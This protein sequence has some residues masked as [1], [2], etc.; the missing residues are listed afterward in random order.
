MSEG[1]TIAHKI[2]MIAALVFVVA[3][4]PFSI[5]AC[6]AAIIIVV[7]TWC[8]EGQWRTKFSI[9]RH[10]LLLQLVI[11]LFFLQLLGLAFSDNLHWGWFSLEKKIFLLLVPVVLATTVIRLSEKEVKY[12]VTA[13]I[14]ACFTGTLLC[15]WHAWHQTEL[16]LSG[17]GQINQYFG[18]SAYDKLNPMRSATWLFFS[19][20]SLVEG[21]GIHPTYFSLFLSFCIIFL[22]HLSD[23][24]KTGVMRA[25]TFSLI[26]Y[27]SVFVVFLS[28]RIIILGLTL[29]LLAVLTRYLLI[30]RWSMT[31]AIVMIALTF[32]FSIFLNPVSRYRISQ[33]IESSTFKIKSDHEYQN[34]AEIRA[35]LWWLAGKSLTKSNP[36]VGTGTGD[37]E[38]TMAES[39]KN[40]GITNI[41]HSYDPHNQFLYNLIGNGYPA[42]VLLILCLG[43]PAYIAWVFRD[44]LLLGFSFIFGLLCFTESALELQKGI[45]FY[46]IFFPLLFFQLNSFQT[47]S[48]SLRSILRA[49]N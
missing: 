10:S 35:S 6:H 38:K 45:V 48:L 43:L 16:F 47:I 15:L 1:R 27:F 42:L 20:V 5:K 7:V 40:Y 14:L 49:A 46:S 17:A 22:L 44:Y 19:Y 11:G 25:G 32:A 29:I 28:S 2:I 41:I 39:S 21:I 37:V 36:L 12:I 3:A 13:F 31:L 34:A 24:V 26:L 23:H 18:N 9:I 33:E 4:M 8:F 30:K